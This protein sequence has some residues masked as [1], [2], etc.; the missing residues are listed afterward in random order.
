[1]DETRFELELLAQLVAKLAEE[2]GWEVGVAKGFCGDWL[3]IDTPAGQIGY[4]ISVS[5]MVAEFPKWGEEWDGH[6][7]EERQRRIALL[8]QEPIEIE[9]EPEPEP[10]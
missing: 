8:L 9:E 4:S 10:A 3:Y 5:V 7:N 6:D 2:K 1:M